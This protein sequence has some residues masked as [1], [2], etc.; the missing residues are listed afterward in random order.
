MEVFLIA[1][2]AGCL[3]GVVVMWSSPCS[4]GYKVGAR[5]ILHP[6]IFLNSTVPAMIICSTFAIIIGILGFL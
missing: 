4:D 5:A 3:M 1:V 2:V 6:K